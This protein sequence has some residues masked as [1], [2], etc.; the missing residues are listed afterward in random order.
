MSE[1][2]KA[3]EASN[4]VTEFDLLTEVLD[5]LHDHVI[6]PS[7]LN[8]VRNAYSALIVRQFVGEVAANKDAVTVSA[9]DVRDHLNAIH[10]DGKTEDKTK[11]KKFPAIFGVTQIDLEEAAD[12]INNQI[13]GHRIRLN[14]IYLHNR[15]RDTIDTDDN[16]ETDGWINKT[17]I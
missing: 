3:I 4:G 5:R 16:T 10:F 9:Y 7:L 17:K 14:A 13:E 8:Y 12:D 1:A 11:A 2:I 15:L 6:G